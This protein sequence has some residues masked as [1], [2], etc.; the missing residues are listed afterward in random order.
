LFEDDV[1]GNPGEFITTFRGQNL[2]A[3][4]LW[5]PSLDQAIRHVV[6]PKRGA[7]LSRFVQLLDR[8][9]L[10]ATQARLQCT[11]IAAAQAQ[12][13]SNLGVGRPGSQF[14]RVSVADFRSALAKL[15]SAMPLD[16]AERLVHIGFGHPQGT[17]LRG[18]EVRSYEEITADLRQ[19]VVRRYSIPQHE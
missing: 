8:F 11:H 7:A 19:V 13:K 1:N 15:D 5:F 6:L 10:W 16:V 18:S 12:Q 17:S 4:L 2:S 9:Q 14:C 3:S